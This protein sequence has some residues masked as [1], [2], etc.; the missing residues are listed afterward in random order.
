M[1]EVDD[2]AL[3]QVTVPIKPGDPAGPAS[4]GKA[5]GR[6]GKAGSKTSAYT[7]N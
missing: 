4:G 2:Y 3:D 7:S 5:P 1:D 6:L